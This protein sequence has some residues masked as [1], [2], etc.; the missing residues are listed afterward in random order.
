M[1]VVVAVVVVVGILAFAAGSVSPFVAASLASLVA[2]EVLAVIGV[3]AACSVALSLRG[4]SQVVV[5][6]FT[7]LR[8][9]GDGLQVAELES[10]VAR[11][12]R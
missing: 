2:V 6:R 1:V 10:F 12:S 11:Q 4:Q 8:F 3:V 7:P 5:E 9:G